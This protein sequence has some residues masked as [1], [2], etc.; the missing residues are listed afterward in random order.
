MNFWLS[1]SA[2]QRRNPCSGSPPVYQD[3]STRYDWPVDKA[4]V[5]LPIRLKGN[6]K[7][8]SGNSLSP[9]EA[10][11]KDMGTAAPILLTGV[12][13]CMR[14]RLHCRSTCVAQKRLS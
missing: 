8:I 5:Y 14:R 3:L 10:Q 1:P 2:K 13:L 12:E 9:L 4:T 6:S 11:N 7:S